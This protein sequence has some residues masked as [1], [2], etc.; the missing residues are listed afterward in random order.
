MKTTSHSCGLDPQCV[1][2]IECKLATKNTMERMKE[3]IVHLTD[4]V[5]GHESPYVYIHR[6]R[7]FNRIQFDNVDI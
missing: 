3:N 7:G 1:M 5:Q 4:V 2:E 6:L